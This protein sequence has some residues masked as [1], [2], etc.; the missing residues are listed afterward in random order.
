VIACV[1]LLAALPARADMTYQIDITQYTQGSIASVTGTITTDGKTGALSTSD[2]VSAD[3][4]LQ[5]GTVTREVTGPIV[6]SGNDVIA[7]D[8]G[9]FYNYAD[10]A[11]S[12]FLI[13]NTHNG[14]YPIYSFCLSSAAKGDQNN[15][16]ACSISGTVTD[17]WVRID[18]A[19]IGLHQF[20]A[21]LTGDGQF[22]IEVPGPIAGAGLP[23]VIFASGGLLGWWRRRQKT[24]LNT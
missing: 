1:A 19:S 17:L 12:F 21:M 5:V 18:D 13:G 15:F 9:L 16:T 7:T 22:A 23:G 2:I 3:L 10:T 4:F 8:D 20:D 6:I 24:A 14:G 11:V